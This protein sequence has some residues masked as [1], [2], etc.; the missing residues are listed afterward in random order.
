MQQAMLKHRLNETD[1][2]YEMNKSVFILKKMFVLAC[3]LY[4]VLFFTTRSNLLFLRSQ[5]EI[6]SPNEQSG[7]QRRISS[8]HHLPPKSALNTVPINPT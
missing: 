1:V 4:E 2:R 7:S 5:K 6:A 8:E 3:R